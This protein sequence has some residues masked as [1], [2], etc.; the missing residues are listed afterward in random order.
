MLSRPGRRR[1]YDERKQRGRF[2]SPGSV[3][4]ATF[5]VDR[6]LYHSDLGHYSDFYRAGDP[7]TVT[8][9]AAA[10]GRNAAWLRRAIRDGRLAATRD[11]TA[12]LLRRRDVERLDRT[13][14]RRRPVAVMIDNDPSGDEALGEGPALNETEGGGV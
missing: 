5:E 7:L 11:G 6:Q 4:V 10:V 14:R 8:E 3:G 1:A 13:S 9:A 12:Y 2:G